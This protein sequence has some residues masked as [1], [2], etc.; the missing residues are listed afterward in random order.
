MWDVLRRKG[1][2]AAR[3]LLQGRSQRQLVTRSSSGHGL[4]TGSDTIHK[5]NSYDD[6]N[7]T[8]SF[9]E[10]LETSLQEGSMM[11]SFESNSIKLG[12][13]NLELRSL[14]GLRVLDAGCGEGR[15]CRTIS[16]AGA[17]AVVGCDSS[18]AMIEQAIATQQ[19]IPHS[20]TYHV[21]DMT[22]LTAQ[23]PMQGRAD[24]GFSCYVLHMAKNKRELQQMCNFLHKYSRRCLV[25]TVNG[26]YKPHERQSELMLKLCGFQSVREPGTQDQLRFVMGG[27][28]A[29]HH[30]A[31][32]NYQYSDQTYRQCLLDAGFSNTGS[33]A[34]QSSERY[35]QQTQDMGTEEDK[36]LLELYSRNPH[37]RGFWAK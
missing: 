29:S 21:V 18:A 31:V 4:S 20:A 15:L 28:E 11:E 14:Q 22:S 33:F 25:L 17:A 32:L 26:Q 34:Y 19:K 1:G 36:E 23:L 30:S 12:L 5:A 16:A 6:E 37:V 3:P 13:Q 27:Q 2:T 35:A 10:M 24:V 9:C 8:D 7:E